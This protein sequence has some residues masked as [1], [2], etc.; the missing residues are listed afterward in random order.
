MTR[1]VR[2]SYD[3]SSILVLNLKSNLSRNSRNHQPNS[4]RLID[5]CCVSNF[6][7]SASSKTVRCAMRNK[8]M[9]HASIKLQKTFVDQTYRM[10]IIN[11]LSHHIS[12]DTCEFL[13]FGSKDTGVLASFSPSDRSH[14]IRKAVHIGDKLQPLVLKIASSSSITWLE[15]CEISVEKHTISSTDHKLLLIGILTRTN[16]SPCNLDA[17]IV[18]GHHIFQNLYLHKTSC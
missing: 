16:L 2:K 12:A 5:K 3:T 15:S 4:S 9:K 14:V 17:Q 18:D 1:K 7:R 11:Y 10:K 13:L 8:E 6:V